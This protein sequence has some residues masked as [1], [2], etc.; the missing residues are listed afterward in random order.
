MPFDAYTHTFLNLYVTKNIPMQHQQTL[1]VSTFS[2]Q[3]ATCEIARHSTSPRVIANHFFK[4]QFW[5]AISLFIFHSISL[6]NN[7]E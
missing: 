7:V 4:K 6:M 2:P 3:P 5:R 1:G